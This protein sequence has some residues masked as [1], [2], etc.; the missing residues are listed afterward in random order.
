[1]TLHHR[2]IGHWSAYAY[3]GYGTMEDES[4]VFLPDYSG[5]YAFDRGFLCERETFTWSLGND[6][7]LSITGNKYAVAGNQHG[8]FEERPSDLR[9][10]DL[11][12]TIGEEAVQWPGEAR[13]LV[14]TFDRAPFAGSLKFAQVS[15]DSATI[16]FPCFASEEQGDE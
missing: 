12:I 10:I 11:P 5:W 2:I 3:N 4:L 9:L 6:T 14:L 16:A 13:K 8:E 15:A 1:M 7:M